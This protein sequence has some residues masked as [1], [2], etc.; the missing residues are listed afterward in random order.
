MLFL[1]LKRAVQ[2]GSDYNAH[3]KSTGGIFVFSDHSCEDV[4]VI[5]QRPGEVC[6]KLPL[7]A[8]LS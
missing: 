4:E 3:Q 7:Q 1:R 2:F 5:E 6:H 8:K